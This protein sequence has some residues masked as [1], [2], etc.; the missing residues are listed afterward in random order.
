MRHRFGEAPKARVV[1]AG[2][3]ESEG[4]FSFRK[5][6]QE[7]INRYIAE[8]NFEKAQELVAKLKRFE[9]MDDEQTGTGE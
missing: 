3:S 6:A 9:G 4:E 5:A 2:S 8:G 7:A 1:D